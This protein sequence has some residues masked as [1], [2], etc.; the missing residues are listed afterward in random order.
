[1]DMIGVARRKSGK[2]WRKHYLPNPPLNR[3]PDLVEEGGGGGFYE[4]GK[5][6][7]IHRRLS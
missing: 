5:H 4:H 2:R 3:R 6:H 1:M 7:T